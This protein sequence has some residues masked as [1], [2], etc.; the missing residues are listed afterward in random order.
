MA[1]RFSSKPRVS[2]TDSVEQ[3]SVIVMLLDGS[4]R[5]F[6]KSADSS[7][8]L[9]AQTVLSEYPHMNL[10][11]L[12]ALVAPPTP[13]VPG[14]TYFLT[15]KRAPSAARPP[16]TPPSRDGSHT[17]RSRGVSPHLPPRSPHGAA[18]DGQIPLMRDGSFHRDSNESF[19]YRDAHG[20]AEGT[21]EIPTRVSSPG[22]CSARSEESLDF[23]FVT[24]ECFGSGRHNS[25][26]SGRHH[27][28]GSGRHHGFGSGRGGEDENED[29]EEDGDQ[30]ALY[31][32]K[33]Y[34]GSRNLK[35]SGRPQADYAAKHNIELSPHRGEGRH[36]RTPSI[37][38][39]P[40]S[41]V[42]SV[43][44]QR[45]HRLPPRPSHTTA[46]NPFLAEIAALDED[47]Y[48]EDSARATSAAS[49]RAPPLSSQSEGSSLK[50]KV[51]AT[52]AHFKPRS[53]RRLTSP[54]KKAAFPTAHSSCGPSLE[55]DG[56]AEIGFCELAQ[57]WADVESKLYMMTDTRIGHRQSRNA[58]NGA[59]AQAGFAQNFDGVAWEA[60]SQITW[61]DDSSRG[62]SRQF[63]RTASPSPDFGAQFS[64]K[65]CRS[66][67][68]MSSCCSCESQPVAEC[69]VRRGYVSQG[70]S[71]QQSPAMMQRPGED[72]VHDRR[73]ARSNE[74]D[75]NE[76][77]MPPMNQR[78]LSGPIAHRAAIF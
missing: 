64:S 8:Q 21:L 6:D 41:S 5:L 71:R 59:R 39:S 74:V 58:I 48:S 35:G 73:H 76:Y 40:T 43:T 66:C 32:S 25:F 56:T 16:L 11:L 9:T 72:F 15:P 49:S 10:S 52:L 63:Q 62:N 3:E 42:S 4:I 2:L 34:S 28:F 68:G 61:V 26:G 31:K 60:P 23:S 75:C 46:P 51:L 37:Y 45:E 7:E 57:D 27:S 77:I 19:H 78:F 14:E 24:R 1:A 50:A 67:N 18:S 33:T 13:L 30:P 36:S 70:S 54:G 69:N 20:S 29:E 12:E 44:S 53:L 47:D 55:H 65:I 22:C 17:S 38:P